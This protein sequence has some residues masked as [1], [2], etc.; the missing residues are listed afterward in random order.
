MTVPAPVKVIVLPLIVA[1]PL[2]TEYVIVP[3]EFEVAETVNG[4]TPK[5]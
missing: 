5:I 3:V 4:A 1:G 2:A